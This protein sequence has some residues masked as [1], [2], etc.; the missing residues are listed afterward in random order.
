MCARVPFPSSVPLPRL[1]YREWL[2]NGH[3]CA[4]SL[5][6]A[7][8]LGH[9]TRNKVAAGSDGNSRVVVFCCFRFVCF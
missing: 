4:N 2:C 6:Q 5:F 7:Q 1:G 3:E 8:F 9:T